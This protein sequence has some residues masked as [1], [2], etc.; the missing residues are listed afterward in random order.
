M[1]LLAV[2]F[3]FILFHTGYIIIQVLLDYSTPGLRNYNKRNCVYPAFVYSDFQRVRVSRGKRPLPSPCPCVR[4]CRKAP[5]GLIS[6]NFLNV[7]GIHL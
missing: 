5:T 7:F 6:V 3:E 2:E 4:V 1:F